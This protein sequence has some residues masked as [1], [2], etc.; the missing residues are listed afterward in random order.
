M[1]LTRS[2]KTLPTFL[3]PYL[4]VVQSA[5]ENKCQLGM[6]LWLKTLIYWFHLFIGYV[7]LQGDNGEAG[8]EEEKADQKEGAAK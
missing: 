6:Y 5:R 3:A 8:G 2:S 4:I 7:W 1:N